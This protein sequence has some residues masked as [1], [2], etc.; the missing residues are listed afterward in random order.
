MG[1]FSSLDTKALVLGS[2][3]IGLAPFFC[4][5]FQIVFPK[6]QLLIVSI[7]AGFFYL[8]AA[9]AASLCWYILDPTIGLSNVWAAIVPGVFF[10]FIFRCLFVTTYHKVENVIEASIEKSEEEEREHQQQAGN[11]DRSDDDENVQVAK[12][13]LSLNDAACGIAAGVGFGGLHAILMF[14]S[15]LASETYDAG[16]LYQPSC[17][18]VPSLMVSALNTF[19][20][21]FL[22]I[23]WMLFAFFG[24]RRRVLFPRGG[25]A[26]SDINPL[27]RPFGHYFGNTRTGGNQALLTILITHFCAAGFTTFNVFQ[28]GCIFSLTTLPVLTIV[29]AY[30]FWS[31]VSK[32][33]MPLPHSNVR[34]SLPA[35]YS[36][37]SHVGENG[38]GGDGLDTLERHRNDD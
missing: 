6:P 1:L 8:L 18:K 2:A 16:V 4:F 29:V 24:V 17:P 9:S 27:S 31:G 13:K 15:L 35:S 5:F 32:I 21:F 33:Y 20:F 34:L 38:L 3:A 12:N 22:D 28:Y 25:G 7:S 10:Q 19:C 26:L 14:G 23:F 11:N 37:G 36:Y 30:I